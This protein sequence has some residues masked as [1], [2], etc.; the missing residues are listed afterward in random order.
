MAIQIK[1]AVEHL[2]L[3]GVHSSPILSRQ[4]D[5]LYL[6]EEDCAPAKEDEGILYLYKGQVYKILNRSTHQWWYGRLVRDVVPSR[7]VPGQAGWIAESFVGKFVGELTQEEVAVARALN[8][9][10]YC[11]RFC[12]QSATEYC[13]VVWCGRFSI[14]KI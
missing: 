4:Q 3:K 12:L 9:R 14:E 2:E 10:T 11:A 7:G 1:K 8:T 13:G 5:D 6:V